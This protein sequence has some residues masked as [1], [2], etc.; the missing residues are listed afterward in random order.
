MHIQGTAGFIA[1][2]VSFFLGPLYGLLMDRRSAYLAFVLSTAFCGI[3]CLSR[4]FAQGMYVCMYVCMYA[5]MYVCMYVRMY[6]CIYDIHIHIHTH[7]YLYTY[8]YVTYLQQKDGHTWPS[9]PNLSSLNL[10]CT[11][12]TPVNGRRMSVYTTE[13]CIQLYFSTLLEERR[14]MCMCMCMC[15]C[16]R[17]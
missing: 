14:G 1:T 11:L 8:N 13:P 7:I 16:V 10:A 3:G 17:V 15:V 2:A 9:G 4:A 12:S 6:I 5:C